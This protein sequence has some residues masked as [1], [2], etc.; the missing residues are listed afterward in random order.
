MCTKNEIPKWYT[1]YTPVLWRAGDGPWITDNVS[2]MFHGL[3][4][5]EFSAVVH[6]GLESRFAFIESHTS[7]L[8]LNGHELRLT[9]RSAWGA[10]N[11]SGPRFTALELLRMKMSFELF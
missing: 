2:Q 1:W 7:I 10:S 4:P 8:T 11:A 5:L 6:T 3:S 9:V